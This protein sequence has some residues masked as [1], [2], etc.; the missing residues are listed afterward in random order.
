MQ[1]LIQQTH[2]MTAEKRSS[3]RI[4]RVGHDA[5]KVAPI[6]LSAPPEF[7]RKYVPS[8]CAMCENDGLLYR[9]T[10]QQLYANAKSSSSLKGGC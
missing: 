8:S 4:R 1:Y 5:F 9:S 6:S 10:F 7:A 3:S 2:R